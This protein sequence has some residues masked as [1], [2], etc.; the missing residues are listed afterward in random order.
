LY[1]LVL[2]LAKS[3]TMSELQ[4]IQAFHCYFLHFFKY[5]GRTKH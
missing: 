2:S 4:A 5:E 1:I 3:P